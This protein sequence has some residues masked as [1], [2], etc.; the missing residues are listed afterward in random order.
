MPASP[1]SEKPIYCLG[2][3]YQL[4]HIHTGRCPECGR[5]FDP[6]SPLSY[7]VIP[8]SRKWGTLLSN[9]WPALAFP[10]FHL[11]AWTVAYIEMANVKPG[12]WP[13]G[14]M[15]LSLLDLPLSLAAEGQS[16]W[17]LLVLGTVQWTIN[18]LLFSWIV[19]NSGWRRA[20]V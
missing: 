15:W 19:P 1:D 16:I 3:Y 10:F 9:W 6:A 4:N 12:G 5:E 18:G 7:S 20:G 17:V 13:V 2:C 14:M 8:S 11:I